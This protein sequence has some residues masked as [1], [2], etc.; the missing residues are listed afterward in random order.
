MG[1]IK[2]EMEIKN[3]SIVIEKNIEAHKSINDRSLLCQNILAQMRNLVED[4]AIVIYNK[5]NATELDSHYENVEISMDFVRGIKKYKYLKEIHKY[6]QSTSSHYTPKD[7]DAEMLVLYYYRYLCEMKITLKDEINLD[8]IN[9]IDEFPIYDDALTKKHY[10]II[11]DQILQVKF[12]NQKL[13]NGRFY[14]QKTKP[15]FSKGKVYFEY[16]ITKATN[17]NNKFER[18]LVYSNNFIPNNYAIKF[19]YEYREIDIFSSKSKIKVIN[20]YEISIIPRE[21]KKIAQ[22]LGLYFNVTE[23]YKEYNNLMSLLK[24]NDENLLSIIVSEDILFKQNIEEIHIK[25]RNNHLSNMLLVLRERFKQDKKGNNILK[26]LI[27]TPRD[28]TIEDQY[29]SRSNQHLDNLFL[30]NSA[31]PF[32]SMPYAMSPAKHNSN[33]FVVSQAIDLKGHEY[34]LLGKEI[35]YNSEN[36]NILYTPLKELEMFPNIEKCIEEYNNALVEFGIDRELKNQLILENGFVYIKAYEKNSIEIIT[37]LKEYRDK[38][39]TDIKTTMNIYNSICQPEDITEDKKKILSSIFQNN[40]VAIIHGSAGTGKTKMLE[41]LADALSDYKKIFISNTTTSVSNLRNRIDIHEPVNS[42][43]ST[44]YNYINN[45]AES[46]EILIVDESS[47]LSND[48][49]LKIL[50]RKYKLIIL[51]GDT[52]QIE[53]IK[54]GDWFTFA[55]RY[56]SNEFVFELD[57]NN[58]TTQ[59]ELIVLWDLVRKNDK[60]AINKLSNHKK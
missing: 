45:I 56:F 23:D 7:S 13:Q 18:I 40:C 30:K 57:I 19:S 1:R 42:E 53:S 11:C 31:I 17:Y 44:A 20:N 32:D 41:L 9:N 10:E 25:A 38:N 47:V 51:A 54:Y 46:Y 36:K 35:R 2:P 48:D 5:E 4:A 24:T 60:D 27:H 26:Y 52:H 43:F 21:L 34:E 6:L 22:I 28:K 29:D 59:E 49:M 15:I 14:I 55:H 3:I 39:N 33:Y 58:R 37:K 12:G 50:Q 16:T 8:I